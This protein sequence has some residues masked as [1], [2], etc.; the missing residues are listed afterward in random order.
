MND[1]TIIKEINSILGE[2]PLWDEKT[3]K[4]YWVDIEAKKL[5]CW[6][7]KSKITDFWSFKKRICAI[8]LTNDVNILLCAFEKYFAFFN[9]NTKKTN[10]INLDISLPDSVR[11]ND[12]K[13]DIYGRFWCGTMSESNPKTKEACL[14]MLDQNVSFT[15]MFE[16]I[17]ITNSLTDI[18]DTKGMYFSDS[19]TKKIYKAIFSDNSKEL[20]EVTLFIDN[21]GSQ[22]APDGSTIDKDGNL[23]NAEWNGS[24]L[25]KYDANANILETITLP[26]IRPTSCAF[27]GPNM[28]ILFITS[29]RLE[30][31]KNDSMNGNVIYFKTNTKGVY[32]NRFISNTIN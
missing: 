2:S 6:D 32:T 9:M 18:K 26:I 16:N 28:D 3:Q 25:V 15:T 31:I 24:R 29:A 27:G 12:G 1:F 7:Y 8:S 21:N 19:Y 30:N 22:G 11:F 20:K 10:I 14:Y 4:L 17:Y 13:T 23:W 5:F